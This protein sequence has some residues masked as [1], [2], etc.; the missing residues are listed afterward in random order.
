[1]THKEPDMPTRRVYRSKTSFETTR[2]G[3]R[4]FVRAG[5][6]A[7][8]GDPIL[9]IGDWELISKEAPVER[10]TAAPGEKRTVR[11]KTTKKSG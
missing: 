9:S 8:E 7:H 4:Q 11:K 5:D 2:F 3:R 10:A 1:V 6:I